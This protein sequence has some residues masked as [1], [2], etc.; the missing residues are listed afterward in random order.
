MPCP[1]GI[2]AEDQDGAVVAGWMAKRGLRANLQAALPRTVATRRKTAT[3]RAESI[4]QNGTKNHCPQQPCSL[5]WASSAATA[6]RSAARALSF[7]L[8]VLAV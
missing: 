6:L 3:G 7:P 2:Q 5:R 8:V 1:E 4:S